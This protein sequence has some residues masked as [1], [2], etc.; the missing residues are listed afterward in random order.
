MAVW[1]HKTFSFPPSMGK[2]KT[3]EH[4]VTSDVQFGKEPLILYLI[5]G[6]S[7]QLLIS[8]VCYIINMYEKS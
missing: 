4:S 6:L 5:V 7:H 1:A 2:K 3:K 8:R